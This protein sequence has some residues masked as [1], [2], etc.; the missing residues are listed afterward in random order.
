MR[1]P[2]LLRGSMIR[3]IGRRRRLASPSIPLANR[4]PA[5]SPLSILIVE[6][7][8]PASKCTSGSLERYP[9]SPSPWM[10]MAASFSSTSIPSFRMQSSV[11][12]QSALEA[13]PVT[14]EVPDAIDASIRILC[15]IDL[16]PGILIEPRTLAG[17]LI[18]TD[19]DIATCRMLHNDAPCDHLACCA[20]RPGANKVNSKGIP[21]ADD[22][23]HRAF[24][25]QQ[26]RIR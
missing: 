11:A 9:K 22:R 24:N 16:S 23:D 26:T 10:T 3:A 25:R 1:A 15:E 20:V 21:R 12:L 5:S 17:P 2:I 18:L 7:E 14:R 13:S 8:L 4:W 6:P 19:L